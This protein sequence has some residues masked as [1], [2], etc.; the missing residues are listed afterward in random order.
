MPSPPRPATE[1]STSS[2]ARQRKKEMGGSALHYCVCNRVYRVSVLTSTNCCHTARV[3][4][5]RP[6]LGRGLT[7]IALR[8]RRGSDESVERAVR[9]YCDLRRQALAR[10]SARGAWGQWCRSDIT[11]VESARRT[12]P[13]CGAARDCRRPPLLH[14]T[15]PASLGTGVNVGC[16]QRAVVAQNSERSPF[17][18]HTAS[19]TESPPPDLRSLWTI[20]MT[21]WMANPST[22]LADSQ[23]T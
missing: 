13:T 8:A 4:P 14:P 17:R 19:Q 2:A 5:G 18:V 7:G 6:S 20:M 10:G 12:P 22:R 15:P 1:L 3:S 23:V 9:Q 11:S 21:L 16:Q